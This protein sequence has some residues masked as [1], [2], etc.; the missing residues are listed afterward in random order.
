[1]FF[2]IF[3][4]EIKYRLKTPATYI[5]FGM[6]FVF[7]FLTALIAGGTFESAS[8]SF[9]G[10]GGKVLIDSPYSVA[11][12][13]YLLD[14]L[15]IIIVAAMVA[16]P[17]YRDF[18]YNTHSLFFTKPITKWEY[19]GA[20]FLGSCTMAL[21]VLGGIACGLIVGTKMPFIDA[22]KVGAFHLV[23][24]LY[25]YFLFVIPNLLFI[26]MIFFMLAT[27]TRNMLPVYVGS[28]TLL[29]LL[30]IANQIIKNLNN[31]HI[32][33]LIDPMGLRAVMYTTKYW[34]VAQKNSLVIPFAGTIIINRLLWIGIGVALFIILFIK[35]RFDQF[36]SGF[37]QKKLRDV[38]GK[39]NIVFSSVKVQQNFSFGAQLKQFLK[40]SVLELKNIVRSPY[41][42]AIA[43]A[44]ML[45]MF[46][47]GTELGKLY[48]TATY[49][50]TGLAVD[51]LYSVFIIFFIIIIVFYSG[52]MIWRERELKMS[53]I[54]D[55]LPV[56]NWVS[57]ASRFAALIAV[58]AIL[59]LVIMLCGI[60]IQIC[61]GYYNFEVGVYLQSL[62]GIRFISLALICVLA[63]TI[64]I[65]TNQKYI[66]FFI[67]IAYML[68]SLFF[69]DAVGWQNNMYRYGDSPEITYSAMNGFG[70]YW[71]GF[72]WFKFYWVCFA[73]MLAVIAN[74][75]WV[76]G[77]SGSFKDRIAAAKSRFKGPALYVF[78]VALLLFIGSGSYIYYNISILN[79]Y[80][81]SFEGEKQQVDYEKKYKKFQHSPQPRIIA[82]TMNADIYPYKRAMNFNGSFVLQ[83]KTKYPIDS[84]HVILNNRA[85]KHDITFLH[86]IDSLDV[87]SNA[88][89][90]IF[91]ANSLKTDSIVLKKD[92]ITPIVIVRKKNPQSIPSQL[93]LKDSIQGYYI[94]KLSE[95]LKPGDSL[96]MNMDIHY[97]YKGFRNSNGL[98]GIYYNG[99]FVNSEE[100]LPHIGYNPDGELS[101]NIERKKFNLPHRDL[102]AP[103]S[104]TAALMNN[105]VTNDAD[106]IRY[107]ATLSTSG[108]QTA[109][110]SG[111]LVKKWTKDG[112]NY[113]HYNSDTKILCFYP[114]ISA[115]YSVKEDHWNN[116]RLAIYYNKGHDYNLDKMM[117]ALKDGLDYYNKNYSPYQFKEVKIV[118]FPYAQF[119]QSF[120][121]TIPFSEN[122]GFIADV[123]DSDPSDIDYPY[124]VTAHELGHQWWAHQVIGGNV[125]GG[126]MLDETMAQYSALMVMKHKFGPDKMKK[127]LRY[128]M[129]NYLRGR[130]IEREKEVP[131][132]L[133]ENQ[134]YVHYRK[135]SVVMYSLQD[136][137]GEYKLDSALHRY[138][139]AVG[140]Q[141][142]PYTNSL[143][144]LQFISSAVPDSMKYIIDDMFKKI[145]LF[146]NKV[147]DA[148]WQKQSD[149]TY[150]I[151]I[152]IEA[153]KLLADSTGNEKEIPLNDWID[154]GVFGQPDG[155]NLKPLYMQKKKITKLN[156]EF[157]IIVK[158]K[159]YEAGIDPYNKLIDRNPEDNIKVLEEKK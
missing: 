42:I 66:G 151:H 102:V 29:I 157:D 130:S 127:F 114:F 48:D 93:V 131:L 61:Y 121:N 89:S 44:G 60:I 86:F 74:L 62:F 96:V 2:E 34:T 105:I 63:L 142:P 128:E 153:H 25:P 50:V 122:I 88:Q 141:Y 39:A 1:M 79:H 69:M 46:V 58:Q 72:L 20:R 37:K 21:L 43:A 14:Y 118:E 70:H 24:Y 76:R 91:S 12:Y 45:F 94:Y 51:A 10:G 67:V 112:R 55:A 117:Q 139:Q 26:G 145:V 41:F 133:V 100:V 53:Q 11:L 57:F 116:I 147:N 13:T 99:T 148:T 144:F 38:I 15:G 33:S 78:L 152:V 6:F 49:P 19:L 77:I 104:D 7:A 125:Q 73:L 143:Q 87:F 27:L 115:R 113:F 9:G 30:S 90:A 119:A 23:N 40:A 47:T 155:S 71:K 107:D 16:G 132:Y 109:I 32:A 123:N 124:Y 103:I 95:P 98:E 54:M 101:D 35:F 97:A 149:G 137:I 65:I 108:D 56:P 158:D 22:D 75:F 136:Y 64:Q 156:E 134:P 81:T 8:I 18:E 59:L 31:E 83:N 36:S 4:F 154:V 111:N 146:N 120:P 52:E 92:T 68:F 129:D 126:T 82:V 17:V 110:T 5:Y 28:V 84:I 135:G 3:W 159:P 106:W 150:K 140:F 138:I 80:Q 85:D